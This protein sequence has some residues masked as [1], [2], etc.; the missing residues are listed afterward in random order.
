MSRSKN[1]NVLIYAKYLSFRLIKLHEMSPTKAF[2]PLLKG[3]GIKLQTLILIALF[4]ALILVLQPA[5]SV[6]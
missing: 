3:Q 6:F 5:F 2:L 4:L 1:P